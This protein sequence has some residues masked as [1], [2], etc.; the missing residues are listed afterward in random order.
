MIY[1][2]NARS[3]LLRYLLP[4]ALSLPPS[5][6][7]CKSVRWPGQTIGS[8]DGVVVSV[9]MHKGNATSPELKLTVIYGVPWS[10]CAP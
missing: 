5:R 7:W 2:V 3:A 6:S 1:P 10:V 4:G 9:A 8:L